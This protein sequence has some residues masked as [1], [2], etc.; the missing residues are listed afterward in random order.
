MAS[1]VDP[2]VVLGKRLREQ[3]S[4]AGLVV[5]QYFIQ[6]DLDGGTPRAHVVFSLAPEPPPKSEPDPEFEALVNA[7]AEHAAQERAA[8]A[9]EELQDLHRKLVAD[10]DDPEK[11]LGLD[12]E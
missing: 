2:L 11:G 10:L 12:D 7:Q 9:V 5:Q 6:P 3:A 4:E 1:P 8:R